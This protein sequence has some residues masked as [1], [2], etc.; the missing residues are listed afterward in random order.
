[1]REL[2][3]AW[4][5]RA[6]ERRELQSGELELREPLRAAVEL[7]SADVQRELPEESF[8]LILCRNVAFTYFDER[9][10]SEVLERLLTRLLPGG[11]LVVGKGEQLPALRRRGDGRCGATRLARIARFGHLSAVMR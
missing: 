10:Q 6:F 8:R 2:P 1:M 3:P 11:L 9:R 5:A 7:R 4:Q